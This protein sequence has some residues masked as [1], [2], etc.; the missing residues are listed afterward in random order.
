LSEGPTPV[1]GQARSWTS[2]TG[3][4]PGLGS[5][6]KLRQV[7][8]G[9]R[10]EGGRMQVGICLPYSEPGITRRTLVDWCRAIEGGPF[11]SLS[12][13]E[14]ISGAD[15]MEMRAMLAGAALLTERV[16]IVP[17]LYVLPMHSAAWAAKEIATLDVLSNG[18]V[19]LVVGTGGR[20]QDYQAVGADW[21]TREKRLEGQVAMLRRIWSGEPAYDGGEPVGPKPVQPDGPRIIGGFSG[22]KAIA[23]S[24]RWAD[25]LYGFS[26]MGEAGEIQ[27]KM[28]MAEDAWK[29]AGRTTRP[30][31]VGGFWYSLGDDAEAHLRRYVFEYLRIA[32]DDVARQVAASM[33]RFTADAILETMRAMKATGIDELYMVPASADVAEVDRLAEL[34]ARI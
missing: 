23:R 19:D 9:E 28:D 8:V 11:A 20:P 33:T 22:P 1:L 34:V 3:A 29:A 7:Q 16:R 17:S 4:L 6:D 12:C 32:G 18:R 24:A 31:K 2:I 27:Q 5:A 10:N 30:W 14:R 26:I 13:G 25:G 15:T 21:A